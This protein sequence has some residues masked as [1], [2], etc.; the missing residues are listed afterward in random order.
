MLTVI[1]SQCLE[2]KLIWFMLAEQEEIAKGKPSGEALTWEDLSKMKYTWR[3]AME[4]LRMFPPIFGGFRKAA[5]D[6][7]YDGYLIPKGWQVI[8]TLLPVIRTPFHA[9]M[10]LIKSF[11]HVYR[12]SGLQQ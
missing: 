7:E 10:L 3:V 6:I 5:T 12:F 4:T 1:T 8:E 2:I 11:L 9:I